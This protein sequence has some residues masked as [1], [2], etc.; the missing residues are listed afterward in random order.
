MREEEETLT[1]PPSHP[2]APVISTTLLD[3]PLAWPLAPLVRATIVRV[4]R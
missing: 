4:F 1:R 2:P 3:E